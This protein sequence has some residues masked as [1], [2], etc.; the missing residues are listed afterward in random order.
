MKQEIEVNPYKAIG[1]AKTIEKLVNAFYKR[2]KKH[3]LL[4]PIFPDDL[5]ETA[6][7]Q[8]LFLTQL[9][10]GPPLYLEER[11][12]PMLRARHMQFPI[13]PERATAWLACMNA[14]MD[15]IELDTKWK[16]SIFARLRI[17]ALNMVNQKEET[18]K[19]G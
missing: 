15:E 7:K 12:H 16:E 4:F 5:T 18:T 8:K 11:G 1:G 3:D 6:H 2:V 9:L 17:I 19:G 14:A 13:T 10:G